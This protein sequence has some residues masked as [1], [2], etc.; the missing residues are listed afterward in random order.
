MSTR[1]FVVFVLS[2]ALTASACQRHEAPG[3]AGQP[4]PPATRKVP[5]TDTYHGVAVADDYRWL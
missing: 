2:V 5:V 1:G 3:D 4:Q